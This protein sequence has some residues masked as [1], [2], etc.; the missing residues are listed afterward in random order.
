MILDRNE[1]KLL[2]KVPTVLWRLVDFLVDQPGALQ[3]PNLFLLSGTNK[4]N[5]LI[6]NSL[7][8]HEPFPEEISKYKNDYEIENLNE[9]D[10]MLMFHTIITTFYIYLIL[11]RL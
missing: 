4:F 11:F 7:D 2:F 9:N 1:P 5:N 6:Q 8:L 10:N 3:T